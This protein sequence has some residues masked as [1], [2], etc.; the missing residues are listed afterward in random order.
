MCLTQ[1]HT[2]TKKKLSNVVFVIVTVYI[3]SYGVLLS[4]ILMKEI[5]VLGSF[6]FISVIHGSRG[7]V[8]LLLLPAVHCGLCGEDFITSPTVSV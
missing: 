1:T 3:R 8:D 5:S 2:Y 6:K 4:I 7:G